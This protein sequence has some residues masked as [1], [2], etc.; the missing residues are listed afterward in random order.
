MTDELSPRPP[1]RP[2]YRGKNPRSFAEKYKERSPERYPDDVAKVLA[3]GKT[4]AG[5]HRP[6][7][8]QEILDC[9]NPQPGELAVDCT[10]GYGG[11]SRELLKA[12]QPGGRLIGLDVDAVELA[13]TEARLRQSGCPE[14]SLIVR[15]INFAGL[16]KVLGEISPAGADMILADLGIS[17]MQIDN[18]SR[19]F[20]FKADGPLDMRMN[21][22]RGMPASELLG[23]WSAADLTE[24]LSE[25]ADEPFAEELA[26]KILEAHARTPLQ[27]THQLAALI[28]S[29]YAPFARGQADAIDGA[30]RRVFQALRIAVNDEFGVLDALLRQLPYC[31]RP[32]GRVAFLTFH[33]GED[34]RV[35]L[36]FKE[37]LRSGIYRGISEEVIQATPEERRSN[38]RSTSAKLRYA[39][40][41]SEE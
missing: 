2:R 28:R 36:H 41:S 40:R 34:R 27:S 31:L 39:V 21:Q 4:P 38:P 17:S 20:T 7:M 37:G 5:S 3:S 15:C 13:R 22:S 25:N 1:R 8:V 19:G 33:S 24:I 23:K 26:S 9:L 18:P 11:H 16:S 12:I 6:I 29:L 32:G 30:V 35:K 14:E 10:L